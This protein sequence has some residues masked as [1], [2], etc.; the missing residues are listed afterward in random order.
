MKAYVVYGWG[1]TPWWHGGGGDKMH[2]P[3]T[4][5]LT[6]TFS[7]GNVYAVIREMDKNLILSFKY[8]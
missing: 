6:T 4:F 5:T 2:L 3:G 1:E 7:K 8:V